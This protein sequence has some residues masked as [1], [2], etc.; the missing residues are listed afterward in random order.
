MYGIWC[1]NTTITHFSLQILKKK[2]NTN[3]QNMI[4]KLLFMA[5]RTIL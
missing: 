1:F 5:E 2:N 4:N 3:E